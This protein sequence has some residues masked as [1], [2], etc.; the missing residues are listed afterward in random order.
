[1]VFIGSV[2]ST[3]LFYLISLLLRLWDCLK[4]SETS[5]SFYGNSIDTLYLEIYAIV[6]C[7]RLD[8]KWWS[9][10]REFSVFITLE[11]Y[12]LIQ[13]LQVS[14]SISRFFSYSTSL[15]FLPRSLGLCERS[16]SIRL[17]ISPVFLFLLRWCIRS[18]MYN[19][20]NFYN[21]WIL[22]E[23]FNHECFD[24]FSADRFSAVPHHLTFIR[25]QVRWSAC[26][27]QRLRMSRDGFASSFTASQSINFIEV[28]GTEDSHPE[29]DN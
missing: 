25:R 6:V 15:F 27:N 29:I 23:C 9:E 4:R 28:E 13:S 7:L 22:N 20:C 12:I 26:W 24:L 19:I 11:I 17:Q 2:F 14:L 21:H 1:M 8:V 10:K 18:P 3:V 16:Q 5:S